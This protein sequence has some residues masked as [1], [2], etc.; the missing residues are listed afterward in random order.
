M[1]NCE[2]FNLLIGSW[3]LFS[4]L[5]ARKTKNTKTTLMVAKM[6][7]MTLTVPAYLDAFYSSQE[8]PF[9]SN[10]PISLN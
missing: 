10:V 7:K 9:Y 4:K 5:I 8:K 3:F 6:T 2:F 1:S